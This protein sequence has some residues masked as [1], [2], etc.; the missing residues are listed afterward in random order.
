MF[1]YKLLIE[2]PIV[3][4]LISMIFGAM[5]AAF[6][7]ENKILSLIIA[8]LFIFIA[9]IT[10]EIKFFVIILFVMVISCINFLL[11]FSSDYEDS[12]V[13]NNIRV[14]KNYNGLAYGNING[15]NISIVGDITKLNEGAVYSLGGSFKDEM[16]FEDGNIGTLNVSK[17]ISEKKD[18]IYKL[19][20]LKLNIQNK[21]IC[22]LG[23]DKAAIVLALSFGN[24]DLLT[25]MQKDSLKDLGII[26]AVSVSGFHIALIYKLIQLALGTYLALF[27]SFLYVFFT[28]LKAITLR[29]FFMILIL[30]LSKKVTKNYDGISSLAFSAIILLTIKPYYIFDI[31]F[32]LSYLSTLSILQYNNLIMKKLYKLPQK[33][34][35]SVSISLSAMILTLPYVLITLKNFSLVFL[36]GNLLLVPIYSLI[37]VLGN[38][39]LLFNVIP[40]IFNFINYIMFFF[41]CCC[42]G[43]VYY[44]MKVTPPRIYGG[45]FHS[46]MCISILFAFL[47]FK[48]GYTQYKNI[49][50]IFCVILLLYNYNFFPT[51]E[52]IKYNKNYC[53]ILRN[54]ANSILLSNIYFKT[55][56]EENELKRCLGVDEIKDINFIGENF[57]FDKTFYIN[58]VLAKEKKYLL[59]LK[60]DNKNYLFGE[61]VSKEENKKN[62]D[63][64]N[65]HTD[66][67]EEKAYVPETIS[68]IIFIFGKPFVIG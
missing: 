38:I 20:M 2:K 53:F 3:G 30:V 8:L 62:Y 39:A 57:K 42:D 48:K 65:L 9:Y 63:I 5:A 10:V 7:K 36:L 16:R 19:E 59:Y 64:I 41:L 35:E 21:F 44:L 61:S 37:V 40:Y 1:K 17:I 13:F 25:Q 52:Y 22:V 56:S 23:K 18:L 47:L 43:I 28:G 4:I 26:H 32:A 27:I 60:E 54:N 11:Y 14:E 46:V 6:Y 45:V 55:L 31:G 58:S 51:V 66:E 15:K 24:T 68:K 33:L 29:S 34:N 49:P 67:N 50:L 12:K